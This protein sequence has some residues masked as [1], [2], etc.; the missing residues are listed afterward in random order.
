MFLILERVLQSH[1]HGLETVQWWKEERH[2]IVLRI[3]IW[4]KLE[5]REKSVHST[6]VNKIS[7]PIGILGVVR[8]ESAFRNCVFIFVLIA[9]VS[10]L[11]SITM[12][13][14][15]KTNSQTD[16]QHYQVEYGMVLYILCRWITSSVC[17]DVCA[18]VF[19]SWRKQRTTKKSS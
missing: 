9:I 5:T 7:N 14:S 2:T 19:A 18:C 13:F 11:R 10:V 1:S 16:V 12:I 3:E 4:L 17:S 6:S 15:I 8:I